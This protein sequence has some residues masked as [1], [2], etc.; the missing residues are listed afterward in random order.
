[1]S[2]I[3]LERPERETPESR[4][5]AVEKAMISNALG[6]VIKTIPVAA[7]KETILQTV[8]IEVHAD[9]ENPP[10]MFLAGTDLEQH[11]RL[12]VP[13]CEDFEEGEPF[14]G[15]DASYAAAIDAK[16]FREVIDRLPDG[17]ITITSQPDP[18]GACLW[19]RC[20]STDYELLVHH[21]A[22]NHLGPTSIANKDD[23][24]TMTLSAQELRADLQ[25]VRHAMSREK[26]QTQLHSACLE[27]DG[28]KLRWAAA[29][30][31]R[32]VLIDRNQPSHTLNYKWKGGQMPE[33]ASGPQAVLPAAAVVALISILPEEGEVEMVFDAISMSITWEGGEWHGTLVPHYY[34][35][36][37]GVIPKTCQQTVVANRKR[38][39][40]LVSRAKPI[41]KHGSHVHRVVLDFHEDYVALVGEGGSV[42][43]TQGTAACVLTGDPVAVA[44]NGNFLVDALTAIN[45]REVKIELGGEADQIVISIN[46]G[47]RY[48]EVLMPLED[49]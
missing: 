35:K 22:E 7:D 24:V 32:L 39:L 37:H 5:F 6:K 45:C 27:V 15:E 8:L 47:G 29:D 1:M 17:P 28:A 42:G 12:R 2:M 38:L 21:A 49:K 30:R 48:R 43:K 19:A 14:P 13:T 40:E 25:A 3:E 16:L 10:E 33:H 20:G 9:G 41:T 46:E 44:F 36:Y 18:S 23:G 26:G 11:T 34:P 4:G 31:K